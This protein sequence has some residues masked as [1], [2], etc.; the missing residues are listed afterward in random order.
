MFLYQ[1][2]LPYG[3]KKLKL[4]RIYVHHSK[5]PKGLLHRLHLPWIPYRT[6]DVSL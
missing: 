1:L 3:E 6:Q 5:K 4:L 2:L